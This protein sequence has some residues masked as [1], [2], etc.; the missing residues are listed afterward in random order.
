VRRTTA[1]LALFAVTL[2]G[3]TPPDDAEPPPAPD[4]TSVVPPAVVSPEATAALRVLLAVVVLVA[5]DVDAAVAEGIV[6]PAELDRAVR[7]LDE[8][9]VTE[10]IERARDALERG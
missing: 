9:T 5:G 8:G 7:V 6:T 4:V 1:L 3:C 2:L 10:W